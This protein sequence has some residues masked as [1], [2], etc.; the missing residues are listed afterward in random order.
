MSNAT[1]KELTDAAIKVFLESAALY[2]W[3][4]FKLPTVNR[5]S[6]WIGAVDGFCDCCDQLRPFHDPR[7]RGG[8]AGM[9]VST[10][11]SGTSYFEFTC[12]SCRKVRRE[13]LVE[14]VIEAETIR[15]QKY[16]EL[17]RKPLPRN[18]L[19]Q[20]FLKEDLENYE[21]GV[22]CLS[23]GYGIGAFAYFRRII[24]GNIQ[25]LLELVKE[26]AQSLASSASVLEALAE[27][28]KESPMSDKIKIAN[29]ALPDHLKPGGLNP[30][31]KLYQLLS[32]G[33]HNL[34]DEE[35]LHKAQ[36][37]SECLVF[38]VS[39]LASRKENRARFK[40]LIGGL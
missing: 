21:K 18:R 38:L 10:L 15:I 26:D 14:Q 39:E 29:R 34:S 31:G 22:V 19:L 33:V 25:H 24:E 1:E 32:A 8:G 37:M 40:T 16:G 9:Q 5:S 20:R 36:E 13:Y 27:L 12:V 4:T 11:K 2:V 23:Q 3:H 28:K 30:L 17:P 7:S 6:L 35:C